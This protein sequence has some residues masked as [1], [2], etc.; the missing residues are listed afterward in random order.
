MAL[1]IR[2]AAFVVLALLAGGCKQKSVS[3]ENR[4]TLDTIRSIEALKQASK[5]PQTA[6]P[7][8]GP[9]HLDSVPSATLPSRRTGPLYLNALP[10]SARP[11]RPSASSE[12]VHEARS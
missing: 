2:A 4:S 8:I 3:A 9:P 5:P 12:S 11:P 10:P 6:L 7:E 1:R